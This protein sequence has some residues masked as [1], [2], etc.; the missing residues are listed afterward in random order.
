M[1]RTA[2]L[3]GRARR[4][5]GRKKGGREYRRREGEEVDG[6]EKQFI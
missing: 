5:V 2:R 3:E 4:F 1:T 6:Y